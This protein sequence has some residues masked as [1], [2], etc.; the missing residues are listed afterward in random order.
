MLIESM[1]TEEFSK[2]V[3]RIK[4]VIIP[5]GSIEAHG[6][7]LPLATDLYTIYEICKRLIQEIPLFLAP[8]IYYGLCR[9]T[10]N[11]PGTI[12]I[13]G[14]T[15][16]ALLTDIIHSLYQ[17]GLRN[18]IIL[19][20]HAGG[21]HNAFL[22]DAAESTLETLVE[23]RFL[24]ADIYTLLKKDLLALGFEEDDSH[25]GEWETSLMLYLRSEL[26]QNLDQA[27]ED[28]PRFPKYQIVREKDKFW[29]SG[30]WGDPR[31]ATSEKGKLL[32]DHLLLN[33]KRHIE[34]FLNY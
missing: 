13:R 22:I 5:I 4:T 27:F 24:V 8:P 30:I 3:Q 18:F 15:L 21:T 26:V 9:S 14:E 2:L 23:G 1:T 19:S 10:R 7:H 17:K 31:K 6:P 20:G 16:K 11:L 25:A 33:L 29:A 32:V 28:Y 34:E 12:S